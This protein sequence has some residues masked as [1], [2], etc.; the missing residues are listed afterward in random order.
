[1]IVSSTV[2]LCGYFSTPT[3]FNPTN[4]PEGWDCVENNDS[5]IEA[6]QNYYFSE[7]V[8][9]YTKDVL[10]LKKSVQSDISICIEESIN[11]V[12]KQ[13]KEN[14]KQVPFRI[15]DICIY[16]MPMSMSVFAIRIKF[17]DLEENDI[18]R[19][20]KKLRS[21]CYFNLEK[22]G[23]F[24]Q[25]AISL[26]NDAYRC[27]GGTAQPLTIK[28]S[29]Y[30][31]SHLV[32]H[33][34]KFKIFQIVVSDSLPDDV[35]VLNKYIYSLGTLSPKSEELSFDTDH[36]GHYESL[37]REGY[38]SIYKKWKAL[39]MLDTVTILA[40]NPTEST[41]KTW[42]DTYFGKIYVYEL[43]RKSF[44][45]R[46]NFDFRRSTRDAKALQEDMKRFERNYAFANISY[47]FLP[48]LI[49]S[50]IEN[51]LGSKADEANIN[52]VIN[53]EISERDE[54]RENK[55]NHLLL[56]LSALAAFSAVWDLLSLVKDLQTDFNTSASLISGG[57][58][59]LFLVVFFFLRKSRR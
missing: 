22:V 3:P 14:L 13:K 21:C 5:Q 33:G 8:D 47:N 55:T 24:V 57:L 48:S 44:L 2:F 10:V 45:Y 19:C 56:L 34:N 38:I 29:V 30:S 37:M 25:K 28:D 46:L 42:T 39:A 1:M 53:Q 9:F 54:K 7:F 52:H 51:A 40:E 6:L 32:E 43:Y 17:T 27:C 16:Q 41:F 58:L 36:N 20:L 23:S 49:D 31:Y 18:V 50:T 11:F 59:V 4:L 35:D 15:E 12:D 26:V